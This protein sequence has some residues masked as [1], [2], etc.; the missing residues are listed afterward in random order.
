M[1]RQWKRNMLIVLAAAFLW[2]AAFGLSQTSA[3]EAVVAGDSYMTVLQKRGKPDN[4]V[5]SGRNELLFYGSS[6]IELMDC[7]VVRIDGRPAPP[8]E[9]AANRQ[10]EQGSPSTATPAKR[11]I[12]VRQQGKPIDLQPL[13]VE[14]AYTVVV[15]YADW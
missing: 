3:G 8:P 11:I 13:L 12:D 7:G 4:Y 10:E 14:G 15:F 5:K 1:E 2:T 9:T 6:I